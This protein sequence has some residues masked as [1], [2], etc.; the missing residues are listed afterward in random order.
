MKDSLCM[1]FIGV[2]VYTVQNTFLLNKNR[3]SSLL[4]LIIGFYSLINLKA[5]IALALLLA[6]ALY[7]LL[8]VK[9]RIKSTTAKV[10]VMPIATLIM[11]GLAFFMMARIG[12]MFERYSLENLAETA[13]TY[14]GYHERI[15][16]A[17]R[18]GSNRTGSGYTLGTIDY[19][20]PAAILAKA[21]LAINVTFFRPYV[22]E[23]KNP[24]MMLSAL[25]SLVIM[26]FTIKVIRKTGLLTFLKNLV[27]MKEVLFCISFALVF[28][29]AVG[30]T[31][32][33]FGALVRYKAPCV[34]FF[35]VGL[36][37]INA[38]ATT[39]KTTPQQF[40][41]RYRQSKQLAER[42]STPAQL[43]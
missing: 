25:E 10:L 38:K 34:P 24:V 36:V 20:S 30:F 39:F 27:T 29:F 1:L 26:L 15:S 6:I 37:L 16:T 23:V 33:N 35:L 17:G 42:T 9:A 8:S 21:P 4:L 28:G 12:A 11:G 3:V 31:S 43:S 2:V 18:G 19:S 41:N 40:R 13:Q 22:W 5:Y 14:Q 32:Y 7:S